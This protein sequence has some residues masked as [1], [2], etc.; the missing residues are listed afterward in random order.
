MKMKLRHISHSFR[1]CCLTMLLGFSVLPSLQA[2][3]FAVKTNGLL[4]ATLTPNLGFEFVVGERS[5]I[6][7]SL[8]KSFS[9]YGKDVDVL[10]AAPEFR[11]WFNGRPMTREF[12]GVAA[13]ATTYDITWGRRVYNGDAFGC[14]LTFGYVM[15]FGRRLNLEFTGGVAAVR[16]KQKQHF[17][18]DHYEDFAELGQ[19]IPN[20]KGYKLLPMKL[21]VSITYILW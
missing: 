5:T 7:V 6:D 3:Q 16:F 21:G 15:N 8:F 1:I 18:D 9:F 17:V 12:V 13:L 14:G 19:N 10:G 11:Y 20:S 4:L 2:Q